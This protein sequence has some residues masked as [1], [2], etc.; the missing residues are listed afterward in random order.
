MGFSADHARDVPLVLN[1][2]TGRITA[3]WNVVFDDYFST[4]GSDP[5]DLP[6]FNEDSWS[7][8]FGAS[9]C[10][11]NGDSEAEAE[12]PEDVNPVIPIDGSP[13]KSLPA[14][15]PRLVIGDPMAKADPEND[16]LETLS[17][18]LDPFQ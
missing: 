9:T 7:C 8:M 2:A 12:L 10:H 18:S 13:P 16:H 4:V 1:P 15:S 6:D 3:Q 5:S 11:Y 14:A 17:G